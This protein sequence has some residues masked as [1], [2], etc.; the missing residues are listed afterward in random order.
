MAQ[1]PFRRLQIPATR[2][3]A[4]RSVPM[5]DPCALLADAQQK[6]YNLVAGGAVQ[7]VETPMLGRVEY[8][9]ANIDALAALILDLQNQCEAI[10][11]ST[12]LK[13]RPISFEAR[14]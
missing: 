5:N 12:R 10:N 8:T 4:P 2:Q 11:G 9:A 3:V 1:P 14:P 7:M 6:Y 13:R